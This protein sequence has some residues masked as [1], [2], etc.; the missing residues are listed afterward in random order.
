MRIGPY[1][2]ESK[3]GT[4]GMGEVWLAHHGRMDRHVALKVLSRELTRDRSYVQQFTREVQTTA[5]LDHPNIVTAFDAGEH[6]GIHYLAT[7][8]VDGEELE[9]RLARENKLPEHEALRIAKDVA[10]ALCYAWKKC[11]LVHR[12]IKPDNIMLTSDGEVKLMDMGISKSHDQA[13]G[14][15]AAGYFV[16]T[17][18]YMSPEQAFSEDPLDYRSDIYSLGATLFH[19]LTGSPPF[20]GEKTITI[21]TKHATEPLPSPRKLNPNVSKEASALLNVMMAK[22][23]EG[24]HSSWESLIRDIERVA[25]GQ[26]PLA[27]AVPSGKK[28]LVIRGKRTTPAK[29]TTQQLPLRQ[30]GRIQISKGDT[31][32]IRS[33]RR[34]AAGEL[35]TRGVRTTTVRGRRHT[36]R[37]TVSSTSGRGSSLLIPALVAFSLFVVGLIVVVAFVVSGTP[38]DKRTESSRTT[39]GQNP[40]AS[41]ANEDRGAEAWRYAVDFAKN[42]PRNPAQILRNFELVQI[43]FR[44]TRYEM[45]AATEISRLKQKK[46]EVRTLAIDNVMAQLRKRTA[47]LLVKNEFAAAARVYSSYSGELADETAT[48]REEKAAE[49][50][51]LASEAGKARK[52]V[53]E[54]TENKIK[55]T[56][57]NVAS[58]VLDGET[59]N[60]IHKCEIFLN[61]ASVNGNKEQIAQVAA[62]LNELAMVDKKVIDGFRKDIGKTIEL[63][64]GGKRTKLKVMDVAGGVVRVR[65]QTNKAGWL[66][67]KI[68]VEQLS[69]RERCR[70]IHGKLSPEVYALYTGGLAYKADRFAKGKEKVLR[71]VDG[72]IAASLAR[73]EVKKATK[74][75]SRKK[76]K[77]KKDKFMRLVEEARTRE[78]ELLE[79][80]PTGAGKSVAPQ[81]L[82]DALEPGMIVRFRSGNYGYREVLLGADDIVIEGGENSEGLVMTLIEGDNVVIRN[83]SAGSVLLGRGPGE[84]RDAV[85]VDTKLTGLKLHATGRHTVYNCSLNRLVVWRSDPLLVRNCTI[86]DTPA[87]SVMSAA[88]FTGDQV[89]CRILD[90]V[91]YGEEAAIRAMSGAGDTLDLDNCI[92]FGGEILGFSSQVAGGFAGERDIDDRFKTLKK[93]KK[94]VD[95]SD[96]IEERP[97]FRDE[98]DGDFRLKST[99]P[100]NDASTDGRDIGANLKKSGVPVPHDDD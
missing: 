99:S 58:A 78:G 88:L 22:E 52:S 42:N 97:L 75:N 65:Q 100:G 84:M 89:H 49:Y 53:E 73:I 54:L 91:I 90:C 77:K 16:G 64:I 55:E 47:V 15:T 60:A 1:L 68:T 21:L 3:L 38:S 50:K 96:C 86:A 24:R 4:G 10:E 92:V 39:E 51:R 93:M 71:D 9:T 8:F 28:S 37:R 94:W 34:F 32:Q 35:E 69:T 29:S 36:T 18:Q 17:P 85:V 81:D 62:A 25:S 61:N 82:T 63:T 56:L 7:G 5:Q 11:S 98:K 87:P 43:R 95:A 30:T 80:S 72:W 6:N 70:R 19:C 74:K 31:G 23:K 79:C 2:V 59:V 26:M 20:D 12:D 83:L 76:K 57:N 44:G 45:M 27:L 67:R 33:A 14:V 40:R 13:T 66:T 46:A 41:E 48:Q